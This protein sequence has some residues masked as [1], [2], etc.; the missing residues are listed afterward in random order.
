MDMRYQTRE[1]TL[2]VWLEGELGH[3]EAIRLMARLSV[4]VFQFR[5]K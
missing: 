2:R 4:L 1:G 5:L 3:H